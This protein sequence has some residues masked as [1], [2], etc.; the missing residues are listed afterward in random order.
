MSG[1]FFYPRRNDRFQSLEILDLPRSASNEAIVS[2]IRHQVNHFKRASPRESFFHPFSPSRYSIKTLVTLGSTL[3]TNPDRLGRPSFTSKAST[4]PT[5]PS[6]RGAPF[7]FTT[8]RE[9]LIHPQ[10][11][12]TNVASFQTLLPDYPRLG[13]SCPVAWQIPVSKETHIG[14]GILNTQ[15]L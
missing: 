6:S 2:A 14:N 12:M 13:R 4:R 5:R 7:S 15:E 9:S 1:K 10:S 8:G 11:P 3:S